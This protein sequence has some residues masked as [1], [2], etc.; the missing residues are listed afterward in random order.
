MNIRYK[1][2]SSVNKEINYKMGIKNLNKFL[3]DNC[4]KKS[5]KKT[6]LKELTGKTLVIDASIYMYKFL[7]ENTLIESMYLFV[8]ILKHYKITPIFVFDGK[9]PPEKKELLIKR[10]L[11]K[12]E[13]EQQYLHIQKSLETETDEIKKEEK[14]WEMEMLKKQFI[15]VKEE[16]LRRVKELLDAYG[17]LYYD[18]PGEAD[19]L[20]AHLLFT[21]KA[22]GCI[23][24]DMD[25]FLYG[26]NYVI[27]NI[28]L[29]NH[30]VILYDTSRIISE[31]KMSPKI[32]KEIIVLSGT[33]YNMNNETSLYETIQWYYEYV[34]YI[35]KMKH[36]N[37]QPYNFYVWLV[38]NTKYI[39][40]YELL[41]RTYQLFQ[42]SLNDELIKWEVSNINRETRLNLP[43]LY[44]IMEPEGFV[45]V[46]R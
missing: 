16:D 19:N 22:W 8:S 28:S 18:A 35:E 26:C 1:P 15:R 40:N 23:S 5:I 34:V 31:L 17:V 14:K 45:F 25:M 27:R 29:L 11:D 46:K 37:K 20:C 38:K 43:R 3:L 42:V 41:L 4:S 7:I 24:D 21:E 44:K 13:A 30:T 32:F 2:L 12:L 10:R 36:E 9:P 6:H 33:D 39:K